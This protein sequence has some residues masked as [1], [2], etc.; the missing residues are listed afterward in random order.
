[1]LLTDVQTFKIYA[2]AAAAEAA[3]PDNDEDFHYAVVAVDN[4]AIIQVLDAEDGS[5]IANLF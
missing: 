4:G 2:T 5:F 1:M 3:K